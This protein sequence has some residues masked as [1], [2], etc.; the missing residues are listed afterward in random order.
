MSTQRN[1]VT[2]YYNQG[3]KGGDADHK[4][5]AKN[6]HNA[7]ARAVFHMLRNEF[8][9]RYATVHDGNTGQLFA[10]YTYKP[11]EGFRITLEPEA[12]GIICLSNP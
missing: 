6:L 3:N 12:A 8:G 9:A 2:S 4:F 1:I 11:G 5:Y 7:L 10:V